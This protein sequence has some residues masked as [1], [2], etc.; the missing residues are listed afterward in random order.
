M[1]NTQDEFG[2]HAVELD[3]LRQRAFNLRW[4]EQPA[5]VI[6]LTA[7]D[8]D[9]P[10]A[11]V[12][13]DA[14]C[15]YAKS[16]VF[17]Y[18]PAEGL[19]SFRGAAA[20]MLQQRKGMPT[21]S[22]EHVLAVNS[23]AKGMAIVAQSL[24]APGD[25]AL[26]FDPVDFLFA[27]TVQDAG[28]VPVRVPLDPE[29][30]AL[31]FAR[32]ESA[33]TRRT[34]LLTICNPVNPV[35][36][37]LTRTELL[38]LGELAIEHDLA[39]LSD[40]IWSDI[41][42]A[43]HRHIATAALSPEIAARTY[44]VHGLSKTFGLAGL[45]IGFVHVGNQ[46][47]YEA[48]VEQANVRSTVEGVATLSQVAATAAYEHGWPWAD[49]W[50]AHLHRQRD[51]AVAELRK[52]SG[53]SL[54]EPEGCYVLFPEVKAWGDESVL[55]QRLLDQHRIAIVPGAPRWFGAGA[56]GHIRLTFA[57]SE[58]ILREG[59]ARLCRGLDALR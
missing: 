49:A 5:D 44:T 48:M 1:N 36:R 16:G 59:L 31:D 24:L 32:I 11:Q 10:C 47:R 45:R 28:G 7:A 50:V 55:A 29:S 37:V 6:P 56:A 23:A 53:L 4:A 22:A 34:K 40:E 14:V 39:I 35:G 25:E 17:S 13:R 58:S 43:P 51:V 26:V 2:D 20:T 21:A 19:P 8:P 15:D 57:T 3:L 54:R 38:R 12:I 9:F 52:V 18:G 30:G 27:R 41:V 46:A 33:I 42:F